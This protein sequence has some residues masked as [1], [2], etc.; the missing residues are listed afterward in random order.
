MRFPWPAALAAGALV[1]FVPA[2]G[3]A[4]IDY[5]NLDDDRPARVEDAYPIERH[6]FELSLPYSYTRLRGGASLHASTLELTWGALREAQ[7]GV[8]V[9][10]AGRDD[11]GP[12]AST[13]SVSGV[14][15][16]ALY[17]FNTDAPFFPAVS[18]RGDLQVPAGVLGGSQT[19]GSV[20]VIATRSFGRTRLHA[21]GAVG[22]GA[23][24][25]AAAVEGIPRWWAGAALDR[26]L[27]RSSLL[28]VGEVYAVREARGTALEVNTSL[29]LRFQATPTT[30]LDLGAT[31][32][33]RDS[34]PDLGLTLGLSHSVGVAGI[35]GGGGNHPSARSGG[36]DGHH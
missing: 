12:G 30:V 19:R 17:N 22:L 32:R 21:N 25:S 23:E 6:A 34:G 27:F 18:I 9:P 2:T 31:R 16:F 15:A 10:L 26:T 33:L 11:A 4:Q 36:H 24:G 20:T 29:G 14:R 5:R 8:K 35:L 28:L 1:A 13:F 3:R 7:V